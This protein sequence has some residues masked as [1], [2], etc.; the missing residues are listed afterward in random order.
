[1]GQDIKQNI[2]GITTRIY[3]NRTRNKNTTDQRLE[4]KK[5]NSRR[6]QLIKK[7]KIKKHQDE[8]GYDTEYKGTTTRIY[9]SKTE[10]SFQ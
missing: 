6:K 5:N 8:T 2:K 7:F 4:D 1:M 10:E 9:R 3:K